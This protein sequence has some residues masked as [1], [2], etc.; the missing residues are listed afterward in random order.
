MKIVV[1]ERYKQIELQQRQNQTALATL[2]ARSSEI[3]VLYERLYE[4][5]ILGNLTEERFKKL[6]A[7]YEDEQAELGQKIK[8]LRTVV[9]EEQDHEMNVAAF[10]ELVRKYT[11]IQELTPE[12]LREFIDKIVV[13]HREK[14]GNEM[15]Q[16]VDIY[17]KMIGH[18]ELP[19]LSRKE[20]ACYQKSFGRVPEEE[21]QKKKKCRSA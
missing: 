5:K 19:Q 1:D 7:K 10:L 14:T 16:R 4:E 3:D 18:I 9:E 17:Y 13:Y 8:H 15:V 6:S 21:L 12:I 11:E 20:M 2:Q